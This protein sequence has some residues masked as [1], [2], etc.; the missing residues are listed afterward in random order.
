MNEPSRITAPRAYDIL[1]TAEEDIFDSITH[2]AAEACSTPMAALC[3]TDTNRQWFKSSVGL[4]AKECCR[5]FSFCAH[6]INGQD[7]F[8]VEDTS[9]DVRFRHNPHVLGAPNFRFYA[10]MPLFSTNGL[11]I[12]TLC[13]FDTVPRRLSAQQAGAVKRLAESAMRI[14]NLQ[15]SIDGALYANAVDMTSDGI[16][17]ATALPGGSLTIVHANQS[18]LRFAGC[19]YHQ[20]IGQPST[21]PITAVCPGVEDALSRASLNGQ[22]IAECQFRKPSGETVWDR[23]SFL[24]Y[25]NVD[26]NMVCMVAVHRD[27]T[28]QKEAE[29]QL[30][31]LY[32]MR[33]TM[34]TVDHV[35]KNFLN[36]AQLYSVHVASGRNIEVNMQEAFDTAIEST[37][38]QFAAIHRMPAFKD[39]ATSFG[40]SLLDP[41][42]RN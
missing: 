25:L 28:Q 37:R 9:K 12:G 30:Q 19:Q 34:S 4:S 40:I 1:D 24:P 21:F 13:I 2:S 6:A 8:V 29:L 38:Q 26:R 41:D 33:I 16:T 17:I 11:S 18:F 27:I 20:A 35:V 32:A 7:L 5:D 23:V 39:R 15:R 22:T 36:S 42:G 31:Q 14:L 3:F 10:G